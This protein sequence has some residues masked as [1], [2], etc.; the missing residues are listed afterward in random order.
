MSKDY[1]S[2]DK[3]YDIMNTTQ[4]NYSN[5][6]KRLQGKKVFSNFVI[7]YYSKI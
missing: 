7:T 3:I 6:L 4:S 5:M 2:K 1:N